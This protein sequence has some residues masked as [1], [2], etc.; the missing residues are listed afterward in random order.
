MAC[1]I[2]VHTV[3]IELAVTL[4][5]SLLSFEF[6]RLNWKCTKFKFAYRLQN[7]GNVKIWERCTLHKL[8]WD[9]YLDAR[10]PALHMMMPMLVW[11]M[12]VQAGMRNEC[13]NMI[14][15]GYACQV[16]P[17]TKFQLIKLHLLSCHV[18]GL[19]APGATEALYHY[20]HMALH[21]PSASRNTSFTWLRL[22]EDIWSLP[23]HGVSRWQLQPPAIREWHW[24]R[25]VINLFNPCW[26][27][28]V[29]PKRWFIV[30]LKIMCSYLFT[31]PP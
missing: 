23:R 21:H 19:N 9:M 25:G 16:S 30:V 10:A 8:W 26:M 4:Q 5:R 7:Y 28:V 6:K 1:P 13:S 15:G 11:G 12:K 3:R 22:L 18:C 14:S 27:Q 29:T 24:S 20:I 2:S 31:S 17:T